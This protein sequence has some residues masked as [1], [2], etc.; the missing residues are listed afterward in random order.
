[1]ENPAMF[2]PGFFV[3]TMICFSPKVAISGRLGGFHQKNG[4]NA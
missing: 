2:E 3:Q 1:M 4:I